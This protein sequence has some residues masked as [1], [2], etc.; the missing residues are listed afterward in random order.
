MRKLIFIY[1]FL[2][3]TILW[4]QAV[5]PQKVN[6]ISNGLS[7]EKSIKLLIE[8][9]NVKIGYS[10]TLLQVEEKKVKLTLKE[11]SFENVLSAILQN[12]NL[13][14][15]WVGNQVIIFSLASKKYTI[16]G[17]ITDAESGENLFL[18]SIFC[19]NNNI[20][21]YANEFGKFSLTSSQNL[22]SLE[23]KY[24]GYESMTLNVDAKNSREINIALTPNVLLSDIIIIP[25]DFDGFSPNDPHQ[26]K[27]ITKD[28]VNTAPSL[29]GESD[30]I[31][32]SQVIA[33]VSSANDGLAG[34]QIRGGETGQNLML[35]DGVPVYLP[36]HLLGAYSVYN[37]NLVRSAKL[38]NAYFP[39]RYGGR[40]SSVFDIWMK[41]GHNEKY[42]SQ[43]DINLTNVKLHIE[44]PYKNKKG[45]FIIGG[46]FSPRNF[47]FEPTYK[48]TYFQT[49]SE[50]IVS[51]FSDINIKSN[52][53]LNEKNTIVVSLLN[54]VD[55][56]NS[57]EGEEENEE[58]EVEFSW[59]NLIGSIHL[60]SI[61]SD[62]SFLKTSISFSSY[63]YKYNN[64][65]LFGNTNSEFY[66]LSTQAKNK[67]FGFQSEL[68]L[69]NSNSNS[70]RFGLGISRQNFQPGITVLDEDD[71]G[72]STLTIE[73]LNALNRVVNYNSS[74]FY[75]YAEDYLQV[76]SN[77]K[78]DLG[79]RFNYFKNEAYNFSNI[80]PRVLLDYRLNDKINFY[81][82]L[83]RISQTLH[84][85]S[86]ITLR[87]PTDLWLP[88]SKE[89]KPQVADVLNLGISYK[90]NNSTSLNLELY[91]KNL[92]NIHTYKEN[93]IFDSNLNDLRPD[94]YLTTGGGEIIG[95]E[96]SLNYKK[97]NF[98]FL[99]SYTLSKSERTY[100]EINQGK[101][102][103]FEFDN[104]HQFK[105]FTYYRLS[106]NFLFNFSYNYASGN[107]LLGIVNSSFSTSLMSY[108]LN[109]LGF[110]NQMRSSPYQRVDVNLSFLKTTKRF[111]H[112]ISIGAYN[113]TNH[114]NVSFNNIEFDINGMMNQT[115]VF[116]LPIIPSFSYSLHY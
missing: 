100:P 32:S 5:T 56:F 33:G 16:F 112:K 20:G 74:N 91:S 78:I 79:L 110:K 98:G 36:Y 62:K 31:R 6:F 104:R 67:D 93:L 92:D 97:D 105:I 4:S 75:L 9:S 86:N 107:P 3:H 65:N 116:G 24:I 88:A 71:E 11:E 17:Q 76:N 28:I 48:K 39:A 57:L 77:F 2:S 21:T 99:T 73:Q 115:P 68:Q 40:T 54:A 103:P 26:G 64:L 27:V 1:S 29:A 102:Y 114:N 30:H 34:L 69:L 51:N 10:S 89:L 58:T 83:S 61:L 22:F 70:L 44:G 113:L 13:D 15:K 37:P 14:Y 35:I 66:Y 8:K 41:D 111:Q 52:Y 43:F 87:L 19:Q 106:E 50:N 45:S 23:F 72:G 90:L 7:V 49:T 95:A 38:I 60:N 109:E 96:L 85:V 47:L 94:Q 55:N 63:G 12:T 18:S 108:D 101:V 42:H 59:N 82:S 84:L 53:K 81:G 80:E 25:E 46:R